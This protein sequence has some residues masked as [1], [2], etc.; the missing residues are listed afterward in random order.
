MYYLEPLLYITFE[1]IVDKFVN[2]IFLIVYR[3]KFRETALT[4][5]VIKCRPAC[6]NSPWLSLISHQYSS[7]HNTPQMRMDI[8]GWNDGAR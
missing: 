3:Q 4:H 2:I 5:V 6:G 7:H 1:Y 8:G